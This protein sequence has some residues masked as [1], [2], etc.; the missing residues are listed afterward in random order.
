MLQH[1]SFEAQEMLAWWWVDNDWI[2]TFIY[3]FIPLSQ[4]KDIST[5]YLPYL[6]LFVVHSIC[7]VYYFG[8]Q[9]ALL[10]Y[11]L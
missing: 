11:G 3:T 6:L 1:W 9:I 10:N 2:F 8:R 5:F 4:G 7:I